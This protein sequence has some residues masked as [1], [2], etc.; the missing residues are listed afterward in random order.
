MIKVVLTSILLSVAYL[1]IKAQTLSIGP[2]VGV[3]SSS[4]SEAENGERLTGLSA[5]IFAN[6]SINEKIGL[7]YASDELLSI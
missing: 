6:Y 2:V 5:G 4:I 3:N 7:K 1:S